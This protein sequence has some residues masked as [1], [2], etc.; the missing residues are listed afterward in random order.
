V[1]PLVAPQA[2]LE[3]TLPEMG[4]EPLVRPLEPAD[5][6]RFIIEDGIPFPGRWTVRVDALIS[7]F[8]K[9]VFR[10]EVPIGEPGL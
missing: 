8:E 4:I 1:V 7:D 5:D 2:S 10:F 6:N 3:L 9:L